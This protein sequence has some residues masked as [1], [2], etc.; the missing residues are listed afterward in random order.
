MQHT[1][2]E[3]PQPNPMLLCLIIGIYLAAYAA[4]QYEY[5]RDAARRAYSRY[6]ACVARWTIDSHRGRYARLNA[7]RAGMHMPVPDAETV[8]DR[9]ELMQALEAARV[10]IAR[11]SLPTSKQ[12]KGLCRKPINLESTKHEL[13]ARYQDEIQALSVL[14]EHRMQTRQSV[15]N[16]KQISN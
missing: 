9:N 10:T 12:L 16:P 7:T 11:G 5:I 13:M 4:E 6:Q 1:N 2:T 14:A 8:V 15:R 3:P